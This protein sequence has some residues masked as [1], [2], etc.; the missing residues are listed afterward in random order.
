VAD[1]VHLAT[2][3][4]LPVTTEGRWGGNSPSVSQVEDKCKEL[5]GKK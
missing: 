5:L 3:G 2:L 4:K 1:D